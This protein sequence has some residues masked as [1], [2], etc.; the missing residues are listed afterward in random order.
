MESSDLEVNKGND[1]EQLLSEVKMA[2]PI[3]KEYKLKQG[4]IRFITIQLPHD[5]IIAGTIRRQHPSEIRIDTFSVHPKLRQNKIGVRLM[6]TMSKLAVEN[7]ITELSGVITSREALMVRAKVF[8]ENNL[9][10]YDTD[11]NG[12]RIKLD[13]DYRSILEQTEG[14]AAYQCFWYF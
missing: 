8:G 9:A 1:V 5:C 3:Q 2:A 13:T 10:F 6:Q 12:N 4:E 7:G 11:F 14:G